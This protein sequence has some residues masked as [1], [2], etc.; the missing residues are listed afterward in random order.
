MK[1]AIP[2]GVIYPIPNDLINRLIRNTVIFVKYP[3]H[4]VISNRLKAC[5]KLLFY[6]S[7]GNKKV[8]G[9]A[10]INWIELL[11]KEEVLKNHINDLFLNKEELEEY[12]KG[13]TKKLLVFS[14]ENSTKFQLPVALDHP[15]TMV[16]E[17]ISKEDYNTLIEKSGSA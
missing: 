1:G 16:G 3:T 9:E 10:N 4:E 7:R 2:Y 8:I 15:I 11:P 17:Y 13:R 12:S 6:A 5:K 14:L